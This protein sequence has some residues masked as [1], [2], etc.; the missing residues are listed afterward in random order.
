MMPVRPN[1]AAIHAY[2]TPWAMLDRMEYLRLDLN[3]N[4]QDLPECALERMVQFI[5]E[6][7]VGCY[8]DYRVANRQLASYCGVPAECLLVTNGSDQGIDIVLRAFLAPGDEMV[9]ARP[10]FA[11]FGNSAALLDAKVV[12]VPY[13]E[14]FCFPYETFHEAV[15]PETRLIVIIN[16]NNPTGTPVSLEYIEW[17]LLR[18]PNVPILVDEA[19]YEYTG[20]SA[21]GLLQK[22]DNV[23]L[24]RTFSKAFAMAG[25]RLGYILARP[26]LITEF[27]KIRGPFAVNGVALAAAIAQVEHP[28]GMRAHVDE[29]MN[30]SK[31]FM[32]SFF[33]ANGIS[34]IEGAANFFLVSVPNVERMVDHLRSH[35]ILVRTLH[36]PRL[37]GW[38]RMGLGSLQE[39]QRVS[40]A[41]L[42][43]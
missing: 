1:I 20:I 40:A 43:L 12:G 37:D 42:D 19:Y 22:Y 28:E 38:I 39:M 2:K 11:M 27:E 6:T 21:L 25:L 29:I 23:I 26:G 41:M 18:F 13:G 33:E 17:F 16:P 30:R 3:E 32:R 4:T 31:P 24:L 34:F 36:G 9:I 8:P 15:T 10:E 7:G 5:R 35:K 14:Q